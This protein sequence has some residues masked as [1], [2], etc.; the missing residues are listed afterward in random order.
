MRKEPILG[1]RI[2]VIHDF[3][4]PEECEEFIR[5]SEGKGYEDAD[6]DRLRAD[7]PEGRPQ[8]RARYRG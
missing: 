8:Q 4:S 5:I 3:L 6:H 7:A 2:Y 1:E